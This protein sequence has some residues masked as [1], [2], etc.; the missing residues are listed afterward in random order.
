MYFSCIQVQ[1]INLNSKLAA[2]SVSTPISNS[3][4]SGG[5]TSDINSPTPIDLPSNN[6]SDTS[7]SQAI[8]QNNNN[9]INNNNLISNSSNNNNNN[10][11]DITETIVQSDKRPIRQVRQVS[12]GPPPIVQS[13]ATQLPYKIDETENNHHHHNILTKRSKN[14]S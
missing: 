10:N 9:N 8:N 7:A 3:N 11:N 12:W 6:H 13:N 14:K 4:G 1:D 2:S 5:S